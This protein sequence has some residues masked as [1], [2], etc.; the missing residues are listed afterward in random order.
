M[1]NI[2]G[3]AKLVISKAM[4]ATA[5]RAF[6]RRKSLQVLLLH[7]VF[8]PRQL[9]DLI[10]R[11]KQVAPIFDPSVLDQPDFYESG[12]VLT[13]DDGFEST[14]Q[15]CEQVLTPLGIKCIFFVAADFIDHKQYLEFHKQNFLISPDDRLTPTSW[16][17]LRRLAQLGHTIGSHSQTHSNLSLQNEENL[18]R[19]IQGSK[20]YISE[21][22]GQP[23]R[24]FA[25]PFGRV[26]SFSEKA[27][28]CALAHYDFCFT[29]IRGENT[30]TL[31]SEGIVWRQVVQLYDSP[32]IS[33]FAAYGG[34][35]FLYRS[36][37]QTFLGYKNAVQLDSQP[38]I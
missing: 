33:E 10:T 9:L 12:F 30:R 36:N 15:A 37:R 38:A 23:V 22:L 34:F 21:K 14:A 2:Q 24:H 4:K 17:S 5:A 16:Q 26:S 1:G 28:D 25:Y 6:Q 31:L 8:E 35:D 20:E 11:L 29:G 7:E 3:V 13:F 19:E 32:D 18:L 27:L